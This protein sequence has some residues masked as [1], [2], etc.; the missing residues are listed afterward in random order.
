VRQKILLEVFMTRVRQ[1]A[2]VG[3]GSL[4]LFLGLAGC[5]GGPRPDPI[6]PGSVMETAGDKTLS[7]TSSGSGRVTVY[8]QSAARIVYGADVRN[9]QTV[10]VDQDHNR[11]LFDSQLVSENSLHLGDE[12]RIYFQPTSTVHTESTVDS[13]T[14][15]TTHQ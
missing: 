10:S 3:F 8:D 1:I 7:W 4:G 2:V 6:S 5:A 12:Y 14:V 9:G 11:I 13:H 15:E